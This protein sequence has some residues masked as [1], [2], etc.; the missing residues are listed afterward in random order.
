M[1]KYYLTLEIHDKKFENPYKDP[2]DKTEKEFQVGRIHGEYPRCMGEA[3]KHIGHYMRSFR[4]FK[5]SLLN[6]SSYRLNRM[7][8][9][10]LRLV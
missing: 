2:K 3:E 4:S 8:E 6:L 7:D 5:N 10:T 1:Q 9:Y